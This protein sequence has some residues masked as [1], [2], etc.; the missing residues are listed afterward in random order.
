MNFKV[1]LVLDWRTHHPPSSKSPAPEVLGTRSPK[2]LISLK[3]SASSPVVLLKSCDIVGV[4]WGALALREPERVAA[5][6]REIVGWCADGK[7][8]AHV[9]AVYPLSETAQALKD[10]A[11]RK[12]MGKAILKP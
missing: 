4:H 5:N 2:Y 12:I 9:H 6:V 11:A 3:R 10:I 1:N 7:L 8:S